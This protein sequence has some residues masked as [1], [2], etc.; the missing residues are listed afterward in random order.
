M[1]TF[2]C[3]DPECFSLFNEMGLLRRHVKHEHLNK[4]SP[5]HRCI[6]AII[7]NPEEM[8]L[9]AEL[10]TLTKMSTLKDAIATS[11]R[12]RTG[13]APFSGRRRS[14]GASLNDAP[15]IS[16]ELEEEK[17]KKGDMDADL[18]DLKCTCSSLHNSSHG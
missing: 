11:G 1:D 15:K 16:N 2:A 17:Q 6:R 10:K 13:G 12:Q 4:W 18:M 9:F 7:T 3:L 14:R 8:S 5:W